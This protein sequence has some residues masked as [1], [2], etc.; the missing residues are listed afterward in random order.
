MSSPI[1]GIIISF[2][3]FSL[4]LLLLSRCIKKKESKK[5]KSS[6]ERYEPYTDGLTWV[7]FPARVDPAGDLP[8]QACK[9]QI[10]KVPLSAFFKSP[11]ERYVAFDLETTGFS[12]FQDAI[13]EIGAVKVDHG[14][15]IG[16]FSQLIRP[17]FPIP[18]AASRVNHITDDMVVLC[19][20]IQD[21]LPLF[22]EFIAD[23][24]MLAAHNASFDI[25][26][27][28][29]EADRQGIKLNIKYCVDSLAVARKTWPDLQN[30]KL[31][32]ICQHIGYENAAA[33][34]AAGDAAAVHAILAASVGAIP[35]IKEAQKRAK[36]QKL[37]DEVAAITITEADR[38]QFAERCKL[39]Q[40]K[41]RNNSDAGYTKGSP[42]YFKGETLKRAGR[43]EDAI[44]LYNKARYYGYDAPALYNSY[45][46][47]YRKMK[48][49]HS[50]VEIIDEYLER[51]PE[52]RTEE[53]IARKEKA[54][55]LLEKSKA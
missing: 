22:V 35:K 25:G 50:E 48:D 27:L 16:E 17:P 55:A 49:F 31:G 28:I 7:R 37:Q 41:N 10:E 33:H 20:K 3:F 2:G 29:A 45:A 46:I 8:E 30:H 18:P 12:S 14:N 4:V 13:I 44:I 34:R 1:P 36:E 53:F 21:V 9:N 6:T 52:L 38:Q 43:L 39:D 32:T 23:V 54:L 51:R 47:T 24:P 42:W 15:I 19:P 11:P 40:I 5:Q 26:F